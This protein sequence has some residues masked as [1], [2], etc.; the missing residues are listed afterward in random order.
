MI[1]KITIGITV[2]IISILG[3]LS[4]NIHVLARNSRERERESFQQS[5]PSTKFKL[6]HL[7]FTDDFQKLVP[8]NF[9]TVSRKKP[10]DAAHHNR[11]REEEEGT[12]IGRN[13]VFSSRNWASNF[14]T[15]FLFSAIPST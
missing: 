14:S 8:P 5:F 12:P 13:R 6:D 2:Q 3:F 10:I 15:Q 1:N 11:R 9:S 4:K 7:F